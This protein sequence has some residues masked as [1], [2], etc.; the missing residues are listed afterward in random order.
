MERNGMESIIGREQYVQ[1]PAARKTVQKI[2]HE[3]HP[4]LLSIYINY[5]SSEKKMA[6][7][8]K[9]LLKYLGISQFPIIQ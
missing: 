4:A 9:Y 3:F 1:R 6:R 2:Q 5:K 8:Q 7:E